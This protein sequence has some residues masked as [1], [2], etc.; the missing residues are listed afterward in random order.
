MVQRWPLSFDGTHPLRRDLDGTGDLRTIQRSGVQNVIYK[1]ATEQLTKDDNQ[2]LAAFS[3]MYKSARTVYSVTLF[4]RGSK[5]CSSIRRR[6]LYYRTQRE[7]I[8]W[9]T[10]RQP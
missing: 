2:R 7:M 4:E 10:A 6:S 3:G 8:P 9:A 5:S 1:H